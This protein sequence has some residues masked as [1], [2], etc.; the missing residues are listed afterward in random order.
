MT[1][2]IRHLCL[3]V[4][5]SLFKNDKELLRSFK[6]CITTDEGKTLTT[7]I[8]IRNFFYDELTKGHEVI[9]MTECDN[10]DYK[11]GCK[12]HVNREEKSKKGE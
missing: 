10:F 1:S 2:Q 4:R 9:P 8:E 7:V 5:G 3:S 11:T 12:G 6:N